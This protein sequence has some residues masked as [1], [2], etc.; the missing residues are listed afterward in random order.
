MKKYPKYR[1][2]RIRITPLILLIH[3][4]EAINLFNNLS[5]DNPINTVITTIKSP[6]ADAKLINGKKPV[7]KRPLVMG[8]MISEKKMGKVQP[9]VASPYPNPYRKKLPIEIVSASWFFD[10]R[11][12][13]R[14]LI[15][16]KSR[17][18]LATRIIPRMRKKNAI[19]GLTLMRYWE[20]ELPT[21][22][23]PIPNKM[24]KTTDPKPQSDPIEME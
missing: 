21:N 12:G 17:E 11:M 18:I 15:S 4:V 19:N 14:F 7:R 6:I 2:A 16:D 24:K 10:N 8:M 1:P 5:L 9:V 3:S 23:A 13:M 20:K 22:E